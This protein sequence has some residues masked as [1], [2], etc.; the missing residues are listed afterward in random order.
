MI[1][2]NMAKAREIQKDMLREERKS[3]LEALD[4]AFMRAVEAGDAAAQADIAA[5]KQVLRDVTADARIDAAG[6]PDELKSLTLDVLI[7]A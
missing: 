5:Q 3:K 1:T 4:V 2:V 7:G 6:T